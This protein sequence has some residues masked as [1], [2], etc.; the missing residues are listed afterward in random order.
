MG[1]AKMSDEA[2]AKLREAAARRRARV[3]KPGDYTPADWLVMTDF[4]KDQMAGIGWIARES[5]PPADYF[6]DLPEKFKNKAEWR[7][8]AG[9]TLRYVPHDAIV[10]LTGVLPHVWI[11]YKGGPD[12]VRTA[13]LFPGNF[14]LYLLDGM[15]LHTGKYLANW[16]VGEVR[17]C[18]SREMYVT[19]WRNG[20][21]TMTV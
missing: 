12:K 9:A 2:K 8:S 19:L 20:V 3:R 15:R 1:K 4:V 21:V 14:M 16:T 13:P 6:A 10:A 7:Y 11:S 18:Q 17:R 5:D